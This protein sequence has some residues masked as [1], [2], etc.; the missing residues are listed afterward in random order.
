MEGTPLPVTDADA[1][2]R[3]F[4]RVL[5][6]WDSELFGVDVHL[7]TICRDGWLCTP[8]L[9]GSQHDGSEGEL[10]SLADDPL[11]QANRWHDPALAATARRPARRPARSP[12]GGD[13]AAAAGG[14]TRLRRLRSRRR[15]R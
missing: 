3:G 6:E 12:A 8:Y 13:R 7:R 1:D 9:P 4:E 5:T 15:A 14:G 11:Q 2:A 10:Y